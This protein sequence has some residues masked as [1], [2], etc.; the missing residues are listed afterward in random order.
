MN[1]VVIIGAGAAGLLCGALSAKY[2]ASVI[3]LE[4]NE[5]A[6]KKLYITGKGRC[7][8]TNYCDRNEFFE[9]IM[10]NNRFMYSSFAGFSNYDIYDL[11]EGEGVPLKIERGQR[12]FPESDKS[13]DIVSAL[14]KMCLKEGVKI[15]YGKTVSEILYEDNMGVKF[16]SGVKLADGEVLQADSVV[17]ATGGLSYPTTGSTGDGY[18]WARAAGH[19]VTKCYPSLVAFKTKEKYVADLAGVS[20]KNVT[21]SL[22]KD[23]KELY[24]AFGEMLF[25]HTGVSGPIILTA[26]AQVSQK[27]V[28]A[29][30]SIDFKPAL[31]EEVLEDRLMRELS[32][33]PLKQLKSVIR[34]LLPQSLVPIFIN[35]AQVDGDK[36]AANVSKED[37]KKIIT[38]LKNFTLTI[39]D[40]C[41]YNE[42][43]ITKGGVEVK[44]INPKTM[45]S[46]L[47][48]GLY[49]IGEVLDVDALTGGFNLQ[50]AWSSAAA[51]ARSVSEEY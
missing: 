2:G 26:S 49:F 39:A 8:V 15:Q 34:R 7:N 19:N 45:E 17:V 14:V 47:R 36:Q 21:A 46:K 41:G 43:I 38:T 48:K 33:E 3:I 50:I 1:K 13:S 5:K 42:A 4:K 16:A 30:L 9:N 32:E 51:A 35:K 25:T 6:G 40:L 18:K 27:A 31:S 29:T 23:G 37:R 28:G 11:L 10:T 12:V 22:T 44:D 20:L 24:S